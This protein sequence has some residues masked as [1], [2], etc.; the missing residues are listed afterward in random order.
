[1][2]Y[3]SRKYDYHRDFSGHGDMVFTSC[4]LM[5]KIFILLLL[6]CSVVTTAGCYSDNDNN[7][8]NQ[9]INIANNTAANIYVNEKYN[10]SVEYPDGWRYEEIF[11]DNLLPFIQEVEFIKKE[12]THGDYPVLIGVLGVTTV[13]EYL[14]DIDSDSNYAISKELSDYNINGRM[15]T[16][17]IY[18][19]LKTGS[20]F[21]VY[22]LTVDETT[23]VLKDYTLENIGDRFIQSFIV[24]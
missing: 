10:Y 17:F 20:L 22:T 23:Y 9:N 15:G 14:D 18:Q 6:L 12:A 1:M 13:Q 3:L 24:K 11:S 4:K 16:K 2:W 19:N 5:K 8:L 7:N 21:Y